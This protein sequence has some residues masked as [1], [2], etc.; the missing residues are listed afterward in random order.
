MS[1]DG[2]IAIVTLHYC[3]LTAPMAKILIQLRRSSYCF[4]NA[5]SVKAYLS[6]IIAFF[7]ATAISVVSRFMKDWIHAEP[8]KML[9]TNE[10]ELNGLRINDS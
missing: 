8:V 4:I 7:F 10:P 5:V 9:R 3:W 2:S 1:L 6:Y